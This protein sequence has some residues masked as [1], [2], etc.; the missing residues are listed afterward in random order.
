MNL[1][2]KQPTSR[3]AQVRILD[4]ITEI[5]EQIAAMQ[6]DAEFITEDG[7]RDLVNERI[8]DLLTHTTHVS[9]AIN[10]YGK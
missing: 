3:E 10:L 4:T 1:T 6:D 8:Q 9:R 5:R 2:I 7:L